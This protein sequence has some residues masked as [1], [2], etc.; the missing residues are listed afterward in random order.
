MELI[1]DNICGCILIGGQSRRMGVDKYTL[2]YKDSTFLEH[3]YKSF[4]PLKTYISVNEEHDNLKDY[5][6]VIDQ[7]KDIGPT[8]GI[9]STLKEVTEQYVLFCSC[10]TPLVSN[11]LV[12]YM[13][14]MHNIYTNNIVLRIDNKIIPTCGIYSKDILPKIQEHIDNKNYKL[15]SLL[16]SIEV[17]Y[18]D[19][20]HKYKKQL[21]NC[22][23]TEDYIK[24]NKPF[25]FCVSGFKNSGKTT[26]INKLIDKMN[27]DNLCVDVIK[28]DGHDFDINENTDSG[29]FINKTNTNKV[30]VF[31]DTKYQTTAKYNFNINSF[32]KHSKSNVIIIEG[33][34]D[35]KFPKIVF[36]DK[37]KY[38]NVIHIIKDRDDIESIYKVLRKEINCVRSRT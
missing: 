22:N 23:T 4:K 38:E 21:F 6:Q 15:L 1:K 32:I 36:D 14:G 2:L 26:L 13:L 37:D 8:A 12:I 27:Q 17:T 33:L 30:T 16:E 18:I 11:D 31:S 19:V 28:H 24:L 5:E 34:K 10:D 29:K 20:P 9:Y 7:Y 35:S 3:L 25:I